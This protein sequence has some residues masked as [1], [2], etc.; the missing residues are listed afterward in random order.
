MGIRG[1]VADRSRFYRNCDR[2][3]KIILITYGTISFVI[4]ILPLAY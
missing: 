1:Y 2:N 4:M 3:D